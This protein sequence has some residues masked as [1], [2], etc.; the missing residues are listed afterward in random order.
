MYAVPKLSRSMYEVSLSKLSRDLLSCRT[1]WTITAL[2]LLLAWYALKNGRIPAM[3]GI[4]VSMVTL[5]SVS[6]RSEIRFQT[7]KNGRIPANAC[8]DVSVVTLSSVY[9]RSVIR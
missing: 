1:R 6:V 3:A 2:S 7:L 4:E 8:I 5:S 9:V